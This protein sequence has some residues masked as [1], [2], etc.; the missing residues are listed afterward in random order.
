MFDLSL[1][2][3]KSGHAAKRTRR[4][5]VTRAAVPAARPSVVRYGD[6]EEDGAG[7]GH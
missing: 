2:D 5:V 7:R 3:L 6:D 4:A 1:D